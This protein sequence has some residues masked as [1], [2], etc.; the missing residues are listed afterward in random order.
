M[1]EEIEVN[2]ILKPL[3]HLMEYTIGVLKIF[4]IP[5]QRN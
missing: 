2:W 4:Q 3:K 5:S 1:E